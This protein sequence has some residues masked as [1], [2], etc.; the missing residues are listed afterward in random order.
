AGSRP[1]RRGESRIKA[2][3]DSAGTA[4]A[5]RRTGSRRI[6]ADVDREDSGIAAHV[7]IAATKDFTRSTGT[8]PA[9]D[10]GVVGEIARGPI[11]L[12][13]GL[14]LPIADQLPHV[15]HHVEGAPVGDARRGAAGLVEERDQVADV[16]RRGVVGRAGCRALPLLVRHE[17]LVR[18]RA[19][20]LG[21]EPRD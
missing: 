15:S 11:V 3:D 19:G 18:E 9:D 12:E 10:A 6:V 4:K 5:D 7:P 1:P 16:A 8:G 2:R 20:L 13:G 14:L 17:A 21:L